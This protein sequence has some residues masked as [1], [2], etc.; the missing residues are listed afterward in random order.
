LLL[1][2]VMVL[3]GGCRLSVGVDVA[4][5]R[6]GGGELAVHLTADDALLSRAG[7]EG[8]RILDD[9]ERAGRRLRDAGWSTAT[10]TTGDGGRSVTLRTRFDEPAELEALTGRLAA[11]LEAPELRPLEPLRLELANGRLRLDGRAGLTVSEAVAEHGLTVREAVRLLGES[12]DYRV[13]VTL[14]G[15][16]L[17]TNAPQRDGRTLTWPVA[18]GRE[19]A[20]RAV[21]ERPALVPPALLLAVGGSAFAALAGFVS[22]RRRRRGRA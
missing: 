17:D 14:P 11:A 20:I 5:G 22:L 7:G 10:A 9:F 8:G 21:G 4:L 12:V 18:P 3:A 15:E 2:A 13:T 19:V 6:D 16:V 1:P